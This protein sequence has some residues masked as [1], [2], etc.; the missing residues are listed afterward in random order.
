MFWFQN[1]NGKVKYDVTIVLKREYE[2]TLL[3][4]KSIYSYSYNPLNRASYNYGTHLDTLDAIMFY[5]ENYNAL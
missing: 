4:E 5:D 3:G 2:K 1:G